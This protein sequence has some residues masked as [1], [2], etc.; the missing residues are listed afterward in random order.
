MATEP[1]RFSE[2]HVEKQRVAAVLTLTGGESTSGCFFVAGGSARHAGPERVGDLLNSEAVFFPFEIHD[3]AA[4]RTELINRHHVVMVAI[5]DNEESRDP[6]YS[7]ATRRAVSILLS[8]GQRVAAR[9]RV[10]KPEGR[11]RLSDWARDPEIF[12]YVET[13]ETTLIVNMAHVIEVNEVS[14]DE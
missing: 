6:G 9:I 12:R 1:I 3:S 14:A 10:Y 5:G 13:G 11:D 7:V 4:V 8:N 2:F